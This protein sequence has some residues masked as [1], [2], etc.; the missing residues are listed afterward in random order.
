MIACTPEGID[1]FPA[2]AHGRPAKGHAREDLRDRR[3]C[4]ELCPWFRSR[5]Q[6][7]VKS[8]CICR[9]PLLFQR[10]QIN[11]LRNGR[12]YDL[13]QIENA[14]I[15]P[16]DGFW[17]ENSSES[18]EVYQIEIRG[19]CGSFATKWLNQYCTFRSSELPKDNNK[20][21]GLRDSHSRVIAA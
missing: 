17:G 14:F 7:T 8:V 5:V 13:K 9:P 18:S 21:A 10:D 1:V 12:D 6:A 3:L 19:Q 16:E 4:H 20:V 11:S 2:N 15:D